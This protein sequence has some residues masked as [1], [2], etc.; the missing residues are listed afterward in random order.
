[1]IHMPLSATLEEKKRSL[2]VPKNQNKQTIKPQ[3]NKQTNKKH[4][5]KLQVTIN[6]NQ[7]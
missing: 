1:M 2:Q 7:N 6:Q 3:T 5:T 4:K